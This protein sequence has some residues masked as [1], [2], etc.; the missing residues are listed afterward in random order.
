MKTCFLKSNILLYSFFLLLFP[1]AVNAQPIVI[2]NFETADYGAWTTTGTAFGDSPAQGTLPRQQKVTGFAGKGLANSFLDGDKSTGSLT[3]P[4]FK[5]ERKYLSFLIGGGGIADKTCINL[6]V[7]GKVVRTAV[8]LN[9][10]ALLPLGWNVIELMG[11]DVQI[12]IVD[13]A[14]SGWGH[15]NIDQIEQT[16]VEPAKAPSLVERSVLIN[17]NFI[18]LPLMQREDGRKKDVQNF[19]IEDAGKVLRFMHLE[20]AGKNQQPDFMYSYDVREFFGRIVTFRFKSFDTDVLKRLELSNKEIINAAAYNGVNRP[21]FHFSPRIGWMNDINGTYYKDGLYHLFY[22]ANPTTA[23]RSTGF[24]MHWGHSVS[25][26]LVH[27]DEW[28]IALFPDNTGQ[29][30]SGTAVMVNQQIAGINDNQKLPSPVLFFTATGDKGQHLATTKDGGRTWQ[31]YAGNPVLPQGNRDPKVFWYEP[32]KQYIMILYVDATSTE[33]SGY[34]IF[35]STNLT[36]WEKVSHLPNWYECPE[37]IPIKSA[38]TGEQLMLLYGCYRSPKDATEQINSNSAYQL[39]RFDG[40]TFTP[41]STIR[42]AHLGDNFYG[43]LT[44]I[45]EPKG[46]PIMMAWARGKNIPKETFN[47][48]ATLPLLLKL[49]TINGEDVLCFEPIKEINSLREKPLIS[50]KNVSVSEANAVLTVL[51]KELHLDVV[52]S[53]RPAASNYLNVNIRNVNFRYN[54]A[55]KTLKCV[56]KITTLHPDKKIDARFLIDRSIVESFWN[57]GEAAFSMGS[58]VNEGSSAIAME[59]DVMIDELIIYPMQSIWE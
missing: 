46:Q 18:Q 8:G 20:I 30:Y 54:N 38:V 13:D 47:Q 5:I 12:Q 40:T 11:K 6:V 3:S 9:N 35:R 28:P 45:N 41:I 26:D 2:A 1:I 10:E 39:G 4:S 42:N 22:Q 50:L 19:T 23:G 55:D 31:R 24:D 59:G 48:S 27:W 21:R 34:S 44:F 43:A 16:D 36:K 33:A 56:T 29:V 58:L 17:A 53:F 32:A 57:G 49:K 7:K 52:L 14:T 51:S 37:I 25:K 15:I